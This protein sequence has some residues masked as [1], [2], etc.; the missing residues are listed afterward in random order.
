M[1]IY[2]NVSILVIWP[3]VYLLLDSPHWEIMRKFRAKNLYF[4]VLKILRTFWEKYTEFSQCA[5]RSHYLNIY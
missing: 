1:K 4:Y 3:P 5:R 2:W